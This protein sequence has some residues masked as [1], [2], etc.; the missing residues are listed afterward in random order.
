MKKSQ[1]IILGLGFLSLLLL[2]GIFQ[3]GDYIIKNNYLQEPF[4][5]NAYTTHNSDL[6]LTTTYSCAN[7][8]GPQSR[9]SKTGQQCLADID[10]P[11][12]QPYSPPLARVKGN[13]P[14]ENDAGKLG[15]LFPTFSTLTTDI[16]TQAK[17]FKANNMF[18]GSPQANFGPNTW[19]NKY[20]QE[21]KLF[22]ERYVLN[23]NGNKPTVLTF[24]KNYPYRYTLSGEFLTNGPIAA[25]AY[26]S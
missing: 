6:P 8:C 9:C 7:K 18:K 11:G 24:M 20:N 12:C 25:N 23:S 21:K 16:G 15:V 14:G 4:S 19:R 22:D 13:I 17:L 2:I 1:N 3:W 5:Q 10:C 26:I